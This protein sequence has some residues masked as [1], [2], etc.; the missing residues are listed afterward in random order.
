MWRPDGWGWRARIGLLQ[1]APD[2]CEEAEFM[3]MAPPGV[4]IH[5]TRVPFHGMWQG[6]T[7]DPNIGANPLRAYLEPPVLDDAAELLAYAPVQCM[8]LAFTNTSFLGTVD[9]DRRLMRRLEQRTRE[10]PVIDTCLAVLAAL[11]VLGARRLAFI[12]PPWVGTAIT[13]AGA[14]YFGGA[15]LEVVLA[16]SAELPHD[17][18]DIHPGTLYEWARAHVPA[19]ADAVF[20]GGNGFRA[21][22]MIEALEEDL[23]RP[24]LTANQVL[25][26]YAL[27]R[28]G[29]G[30]RVSGYGRI[31]DEQLPTAV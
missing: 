24:V 25:F 9:D 23:Q 21:I 14:A 28:T 19:G 31:F 13:Q 16:Q 2:M 12:N 30:A 7:L 29:S 18:R 3:A 15:G 6:A 1:A 8:C 26:W 20:V 17:P 5:T 4:S 27:R 10:I 11:Q 22:G